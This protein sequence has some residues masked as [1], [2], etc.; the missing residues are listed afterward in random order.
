VLWACR[1]SS[2]S[3]CGSR[4]LRDHRHQPPPRLPAVV[5]GMY[6][7]TFWDWSPTSGPSA[8]PD[9]AAPVHPLPAMI[10]IF[11]MRTHRCGGEV[12][13][14]GDRVRDRV[15][16]ERQEEGARTHARVWAVSACERCRT[17]ACSTLA[18][19]IHALSPG[20]RGLV[21]YGARRSLRNSGRV[22]QPDGPRSRGHKAR[23]AGYRKMDAYSPSPSRSSTTPSACPTR[24]ARGLSSAA[25]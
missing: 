19:P 14:T 11:E 20:L 1:S 9:T 16:R 5:V 23:E 12:Q 7:P 6:S 8:V 22:R 18:S 15:R 13:R 21:F 17:A 4:A 10:A 24:A 3:A 25:A 2:T